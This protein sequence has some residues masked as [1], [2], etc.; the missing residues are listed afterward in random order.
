MFIR[1]LSYVYEGK[2]LFEL[3]VKPNKDIKKLPYKIVSKGA[4]MLKSTSNGFEE[5]LRIPRKFYC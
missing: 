4:L 5:Y 1:T 2:T 3:F